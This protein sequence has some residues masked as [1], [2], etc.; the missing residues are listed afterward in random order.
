MKV[1]NKERRP[2][3]TTV[4]L[5]Y[6]MLFLADVAYPLSVKLSDKLLFTGNSLMN[7]KTT[8]K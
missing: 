6:A 1:E 8:K 7:G 5:A 2:L 3:I 4:I